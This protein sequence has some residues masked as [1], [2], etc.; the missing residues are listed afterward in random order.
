MNCNYQPEK[1]NWLDAVNDFCIDFIDWMERPKVSKWF[2][3]ALL[4][5]LIVT[6]IY[7]VVKTGYD[8]STGYKPTL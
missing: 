3:R 6:I 2:N 5:F 8:L 1:R 7:L 4:T